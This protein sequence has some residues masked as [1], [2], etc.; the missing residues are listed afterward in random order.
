MFGRSGRDVRR[1]GNSRDMIEQPGQLIDAYLDD[2]LDETQRAAFERRLESDARLRAEVERQRRIDGSLGRLFAP[3][4]GDHVV[5][6]ITTLAAK[7]RRTARMPAR[8]SRWR[9]F[10]IAA[11]LALG[12][13]GV[14]RLW[15]FGFP[16]RPSDM[17][18]PQPWRSFETVYRDTVARGFKPGWVC[19]DDREFMTAF[20]RQLGQALLL[21]PP[22]PGIGVSCRSHPK[23]LA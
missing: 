5:S 8:V 12:I 22:P 17:Y 16:V 23:R 20:R 11:A 13:I 15:D 18:A 1:M 9:R 19:K 7:D 21:V 3:P 2:L 10:A 14:Y 6:R 4:V